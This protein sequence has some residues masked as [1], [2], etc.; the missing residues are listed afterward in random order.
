MLD[1][2]AQLVLA[3][4]LDVAMLLHQLDDAHRV[5]GGRGLEL[6]RD[7]FLARIDLEDAE[8]FGQQPKAVRLDERLG[9]LRQLAEAVDELFLDEEKVVW[10]WPDVAG[11][12]IEEFR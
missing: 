4:E 12:A 2:D 10:D 3:S 5:D 11:R 1:L 8:R 6:Q 9:L 7:G